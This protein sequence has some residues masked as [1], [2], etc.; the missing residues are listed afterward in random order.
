MDRP[1]AARRQLERMRDAARRHANNALTWTIFAAGALFRVI[2]YSSG[3]SLWVDE[4]HVAIDV[5]ERSYVALA[6][7]LHLGSVAPLGFLWAARLSGEWFGFSEYTLRLFPFLSSIAGMGVF[8]LL[9]RRVLAPKAVPLA[10]GIF[11]ISDKLIYYGADFKPYSSDVLIACLLLWL[12]F[13]FD[14]NAIEK[15][16]STRRDVVALCIAGGL[17]PWFSITSIFITGSI[18]LTWVAVSVWK[19]DW[20]RLTRVILIGSVWVLNLAGCYVVQWRNFAENTMMQRYWRRA[21]GPT[22]DSYDHVM[23]YVNNLLQIFKT[24]LGLP[25][26]GLALGLCIVGAHTLAK[27]RSRGHLAMF[28]MPIAMALLASGLE[29]YP[30]TASFGGGRTILFAIP[31][32]APLVAGGLWRIVSSS[33]SSVVAFGLVTVLLFRP[34]EHRYD[35]MEA[36]PRLKEEARPVLEHVV[37]HWQP[38]DTIYV[39]YGAAEAFRLYRQLLHWEPKSVVVGKSSRGRVRVWRKDIARL[40]RRKR[41][42]FFFAHVHRNEQ[43]TFIKLL[44]KQGVHR[45]TLNAKG[46]AVVLYDLSAQARAKRKKP[47]KR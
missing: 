11:A 5:V 40:R 30:F 35:T 3:R 8:L 2:E 6:E 27:R 45:D 19:R 41:V 29:K 16:K 15:G 28:L 34:I 9:C 20:K 14:D 47:K 36:A 42:W 12:T 46:A 25:L 39:Y 31:L 1:N 7:P 17:A 32:L 23:W 10:L 44:N 33:R 13:R 21:F 18:G 38:G 24:P 4:A 37:A 43:R 26:T 22:P